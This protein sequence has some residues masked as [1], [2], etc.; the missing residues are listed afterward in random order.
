MPEKFRCLLV[1]KGG[2]V[3]VERTDVVCRFAQS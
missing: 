3:L 1:P 2:Q